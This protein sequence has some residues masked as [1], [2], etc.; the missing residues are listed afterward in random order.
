MRVQP[1]TEKDY[2]P[3]MVNRSLSFSQDAVLPANAM[4]TN[5]FLDKRMQ[6]D[7]LYGS[8]R[9]RKRFDKWQKREIEDESLVKSVMEL[10]SIGQRRAIEYIS[11][12]TPNQREE[13]RKGYGG[14]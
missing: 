4:N 7:F 14:A 9:R 5:W 8:V 11:M 13:I 2:L 6:Y 1:E 12:M 10:Y 3:F